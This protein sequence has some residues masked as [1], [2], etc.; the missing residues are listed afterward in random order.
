MTHIC[1]TANPG[2]T[3]LPG[4]KSLADRFDGFVIDVWGVLHDGEKPF[5]GTLDC[6][7]RL[8]DA[9]KRTVLLSNVARRAHMLAED[10]AAMGIDRTLYGGLMTSGESAWV[11]LTRRADSWHAALGSKCLFLGPVKQDRIIEGLDLE[12]VESARDADFLMAARTMKPGSDG[13]EWT[14]D[15]RIAAEREIPMLCANPDRVAII[16]PHRVTCPGT[17]AARF[18]D[19]GGEVFFHGKPYPAIYDRALEILEIKD[20]T[21]VA[22][23]GDGLATDIAG[24]HNSGLGKILV[25]SGIHA[26][27]IGPWPPDPAALGNLFRQYSHEPDAFIPEFRWEP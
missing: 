4:M 5:P 18:I 22:G 2:W 16:G 19:M 15:L 17:L 11:A 6:L 20:R 9:G 7:R 24:A 26:D 1:G 27:A 12:F 14:P 3:I 10:L 8:A 13:E 23:I 21:R 25:A